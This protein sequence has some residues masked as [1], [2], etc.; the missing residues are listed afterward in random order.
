MRSV[1]LNND[2]YDDALD[3]F[4]IHG[5]GGIFGALATGL[6]ASKSVNPAGADGLLLGNPQLFV[7]QVVAVTATCLFAVIVT[8]I[9]LKFLDHLVGLRV[10]EEDEEAG[11]DIS[12]HGED[13]YCYTDLSATAE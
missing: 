10:A 8:G 5:V 3:A 13:A 4:G 11:L 2:C 6:L 1:W 12:Q 9:I 7:A